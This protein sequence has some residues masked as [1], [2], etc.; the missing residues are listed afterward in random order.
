M[1][2]PA[3]TSAIA[4]L[5][6]FAIYIYR[7]QHQ[8]NTSERG[9]GCGPVT[10]H[11]SKEPFSGVDFHMRM[12]ADM[13]SLYQHHQRYGKTFQLQTFIA[14][15]AI[16]TLA[17]ANI[18][19][20]NTAKEFGV[21][22]MRLPS[23]EYFCGRGFLTTDGD[24]WQHSRK[25]LKPGFAKHN[26][27][28]LDFLSQQ[29][30]DLLA[31][32]PVQGK[33]VDLQP[34]FYTL[35][36]HTRSSTGI[37][38]L[39]LFV[40]FLN[41]SVHF[42]LGINPNEDYKG[43]P[44]TSAEFIEAFHDALFYTMFRAILGRAWFIVPKRKYLDACRTAHEYLDYY[45]DQALNHQS[46]SR[47]ST[48][49]AKTRSLL[50][51]LSD[52]TSDLKFI[53]HQILQGMMASQETTSA[54]LGNACLLLSRH[55]KYWGQIR[56]EALKAGAA[57]YDFDTLL[58]LVSVHN[59]LLE[60]LRLYPVFPL[61]SRDTLKDTQLPTGG[62][63]DQN[64]PM[65]V[66]KGT[67]VVLSYY[68]LHRDTTVFGEDVEEFKPERWETIKPGTWDFMGFGG[69]NRA[70]MGQQKVLVEA[71]YVLVRLAKQYSKLESRDSSAWEGEMKLTC[72]SKNGCK[73]AL[74]S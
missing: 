13:P 56:L 14:Q 7:L 43:A 16:M 8:R 70:C 17:T 21:E 31:T 46:S 23:M 45:I 51:N 4:G 5:A 19:A 67:V 12:Y 53:R 2:A 74:F 29:V 50:G 33:T 25:L 73:V 68:A 66:P 22:P 58:S 59:V 32:L 65:F 18:R 41:T 72:K 30:D 24:L 69:G 52:Q 28:N 48:P 10:K 49:H 60:T 36:I 3:V 15:P 37:A 20:V 54:L 35:V 11:R 47:I 40:Q 38:A 71:A 42:L 61:L 55:P 34:M 64:L 57:V 1:L 6:I 26:L 27:V 9:N 63:K 44:H 62:G 39:I